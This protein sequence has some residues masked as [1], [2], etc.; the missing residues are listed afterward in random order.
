MIHSIHA[1]KGFSIYTTDGEIGKVEDCYFD[2]EQWTVRYLVV[3]TGSWLFGKEV[4]LSPIVIKRIDFEHKDIVCNITSDQVKNSPSVESEKPISKQQ[5]QEFSKYFGYPVYWGGAGF[6][7]DAMNP[8]ALVSKSD[9]AEPA[10]SDDAR[11]DHHLRSINEV[12]GYRIHTDDGE[13]GH[14]ED[15][16]LDDGKWVIRYMEVHIPGLRHG[17][18]VIISP[19]WIR[20]VDWAQAEV[21]VG[22]HKE[23][24]ENAPAY[25]PSVPITREYE[26]SLLEYYGE[27]KYWFEEEG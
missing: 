20:G 25:D 11:Y 21:T 10:E 13:A 1:I 16:F 2:D 8:G 4:L 26:E 14:V 12:C 17:K 15:F 3:R 22:I 7:G 18:K 27:S 19:R 9:K 24:I 6:W 5:E 23:K